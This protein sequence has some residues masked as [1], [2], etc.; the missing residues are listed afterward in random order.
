MESVEAA[1]RISSTKATISR[2]RRF[3]ARRQVRKPGDKQIK[4]E[5]SR[6][7]TSG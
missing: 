4:V 5:S 2:S 7:K 3:D 1:P 6:W